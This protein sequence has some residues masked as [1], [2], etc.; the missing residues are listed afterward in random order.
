VVLRRALLCDQS[1]AEGP[2]FLRDVLLVAFEI[3]EGVCLSLFEEGVPFYHAVIAAVCTEKHVAWQALENLE[4]LSKIESVHDNRYCPD[5][6]NRCTVKGS[7]R[8]G[9]TVPFRFKRK[10]NG[11]VLP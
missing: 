8:D 7:G 10:G 6:D 3:H 11:T 9:R 1:L 4:R 5:Q 2:L